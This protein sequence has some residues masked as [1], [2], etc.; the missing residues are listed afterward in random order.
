MKKT[1][2]LYW[3]YTGL[4]SA[5]MLFSSIPDILKDEEAIKFIATLGYPEYFVPFI[6]Y[7][8]ILGVIGILVPGYPRIKEWAYAGLVFDLVGAVYSQVATSGFVVQETFMILPLTLAA[9][10]YLFYH[11]KIKNSTL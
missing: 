2:T 9:L 4:F 3:I 7:A 1:N 11:K 6:G 8:K 5:L 10:S